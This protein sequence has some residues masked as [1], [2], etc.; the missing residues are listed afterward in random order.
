MSLIVLQQN[1]GFRGAANLI[2]E[3][4]NRGNTVKQGLKA[5][6]SLI[7]VQHNNKGLRGAVI[8]IVVQQN[9]GCKSGASLF[10]Q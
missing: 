7:V 2:V 5:A 9:R 4:Q 3:Q 8:L 1:R 6:L 10:A